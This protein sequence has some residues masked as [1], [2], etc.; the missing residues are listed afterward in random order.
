MHLYSS[1]QTM[2]MK[3]AI[4]IFVLVQ[5]SVLRVHVPRVLPLPIVSTRPSA[6]QRAP[7]CETAGTDQLAITCM[8]L[9]A[10]AG[11][12]DARFVPRVILNRAAISFK[13]SNESHM[14]VELSFTN[15]SGGQISETRTVY[16]VIDDEKGENHMRRPL[17]HVDFTKLEPGKLT[18]FEDTLMAPAFAPGPYVVSLWIPSADL[19][20]K[21][22]SAHNF[23]LSSAGVP[24]S[25]SALNRIAKFRAVAP[26]KRK[27]ADVPD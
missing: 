8:F 5:M 21:F 16:L 26:G 6:S 17:P 19:A 1:T 25:N 27:S 13:T 23:L 22:N 24:D 7:Q 20:L 18:K 11:G 4:S 3:M 15:D 9:P 10:D 2:N 14:R 12:T